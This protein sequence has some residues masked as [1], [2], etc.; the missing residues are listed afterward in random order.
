M[1]VDAAEVPAVGGRGR[2]SQTRTP[3]TAAA[4]AAVVT[5]L[6]SWWFAA[7]VL[8]GFAAQA[9]WIAL[10]AR[11]VIYDEKYHLLAIEAFSHRRTPILDQEITDGAIGDAE[12]YGSWVYHYLMSIPWRA[13]RGAGVEADTRIVVLRLVTVLMVTAALL[14][15]RKVFRDLGASRAVANVTL[16]V[17]AGSP[18]LVFLSGAVSYDNMLFLVAAGFYLAVLRVWKAEGFDLTGWLA[19]I[20]LAGFG[21]VTK[22]TFL[23]VVAILGVALLVRQAGA[24]RRDA[25]P[26]A[27]GYLRGLGRSALAR[28]IALILAALLGIVV[29]VERYV[30]N[31]VVYRALT[32]AC[33]AVHETDICAMFGPW[34]RNVEL[35]ESFD[36]L[37]PSLHTFL[38]YLGTQWVPLMFRYSTL[39]GVVDADDVSRSTTGPAVTGA[40]T[41]LFVVALGV[42][43]VIGWGAV[44]QIAGARLLLAASAFYLL[45]LFVQNYTDYLSM[46][47]AVG[48]ASRYALLVYPLVLGVACL[49]VSRI[50]S[51]TSVSGGRGLKVLLVAG[52]LLCLLQGGGFLS[53]LVSVE[54]EWLQDPDGVV[55]RATLRLADVARWLVLDDSLVEDPRF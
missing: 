17:L 36:A 20:A 11:L 25:V 22:Y 41:A 50:V 1:S 4:L 39:I 16:L 33:E 5:A 15:F 14:V 6:G 12:R 24:I 52:L 8:V 37:S 13:M 46:G 32:P 9:A 51:L 27:R 38:D 29:V 55:G 40:L 34:A 45:A 42:V 54:L 26:A 30:V 31:L 19:V 44:K 23:P 7:A 3:R 21:S 49:V 47:V 35:R 18:L 28:R 48:V 2:R 43:L 53:Y 10:S